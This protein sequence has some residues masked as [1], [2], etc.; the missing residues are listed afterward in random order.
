MENVVGTLRDLSK[1]Q[2]S[3]KANSPTLLF[4]VYN[5]TH[6]Y[7]TDT[8]NQYVKQWI[9]SFLTQLGELTQT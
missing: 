8:A 3:I 5:T 1:L 7:T 9:F 6:R 4:L 2:I